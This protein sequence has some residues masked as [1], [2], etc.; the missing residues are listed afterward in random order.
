MKILKIKKLL[1]LSIFFLIILVFNYFLSLDI[2]NKI[3]NYIKNNSI[4]IITLTPS[5]SLENILLILLVLQLLIFIPFI[6]MIIYNSYKDA[7]YEKEKKIIKKFPFFYIIGLF[8]FLFGLY[9]GL[10]LMLPFML[11]YNSFLGLDNILTLNNLIKTIIFNGLIFFII[12]QIPFIIKSL[13][14]LNFID[15]ENFKKKRKVIF[16]ICLIFGGI[17]SPTEFFTMF[18]ISIPLY[19]SYELGLI[20]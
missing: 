11:Q 8:G 4:E 18:L 15:L 14:K 2:L 5:E 1:L 9:V 13:R 10:T 6:S 16:F 3:I 12:F 20:I 17:L 7:L 19:L